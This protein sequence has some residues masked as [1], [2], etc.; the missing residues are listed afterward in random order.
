MFSTC[1]PL[2]WGL[3]RWW[4]TKQINN[5]CSLGDNGPWSPWIGPAWWKGWGRER[6]FCF[7]CNVEEPRALAPTSQQTQGATQALHCV[8]LH[9]GTSWKRGPGRNCRDV[10]TKCRD[11]K[12]VPSVIFPFLMKVSRETRVTNAPIFVNT[13]E[14]R[15][16]MEAYWV[17]LFIY[18][19]NTTPL[20]NLRY[21]KTV[22][23][24]LK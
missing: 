13:S 20:K 3:G 9:K 22:I 21:L 15:Y 8:L 23:K 6:V 19:N 5:P 24:F 2:F 16:S 1:Q 12:F 7:Q 17:K 10:D 18:P 4:C 14:Y 11:C